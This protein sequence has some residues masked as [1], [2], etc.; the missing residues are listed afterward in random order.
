LW[1]GGRNDENEEGTGRKRKK[2]R[3]RVVY[4][5]VTL[6]KYCITERQH[7]CRLYNTDNFKPCKIEL[8]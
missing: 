3:V 8:S 6:H 4:I 1:E 7:G 2:V 5:Y